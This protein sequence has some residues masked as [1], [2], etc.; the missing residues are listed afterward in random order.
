MRVSGRQRWRL[1]PA[2]ARATQIALRERVDHADRTGAVRLVAGI[3]VG[4]EGSGTIARA[5]VAVLTFPGLELVEFALAREPTRFPYIP[6][7]LSF[8]E[9][10]VIL[11]ALGRLDSR[12]DVLLC[13]GHGYAH[14]RRFGLACHLGIIADIPTIGIGKSRLVGTYT[15]VPNRRGAWRALVD[16]G[17]TIGAVLRSRSAVKPIFVSIGH[18]VDLSRAIA[19][20]M[21]CATR[22]RLPETTRWAHRLASCAQ[23]E[24]VK[25]RHKLRAHKRNACR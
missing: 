17:E 10:P 19:L 12:P 18:K 16:A 21:A 3:D 25:L 7:L 4:F 24:C 2:E 11:K 9:A 6:G 22:Y 1:S 14:P 23:D 5:A 20:V 13:D 15:P 8:R